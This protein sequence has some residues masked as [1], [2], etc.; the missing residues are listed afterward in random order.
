[1]SRDGPKERQLR[2]SKR[3]V[4]PA[5]PL[6]P[7]R[8]W[9]TR[10]YLMCVKTKRHYFI[11]ISTGLLSLVFNLSFWSLWGASHWTLRS[12][13][14]DAIFVSPPLLTRERH[15]DRASKYIDYPRIIAFSVVAVFPVRPFCDRL[16]P[17]R[18][19]RLCSPGH[20]C[21]CTPCSSAVGTTCMCRHQVPLL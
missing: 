5:Q 21:P 1:M 7:S 18:L 12:R 10:R 16:S 11:C 17:P 13:A 19:F 14:R 15:K 2:G 4:D 6:T 9:G 8:R 3:Q 20:V